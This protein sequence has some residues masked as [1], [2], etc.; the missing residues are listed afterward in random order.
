ML[1]ILGILI[2]LL[3]IVGVTKLFDDKDNSPKQR[4]I[5]ETIYTACFSIGGF[6]VAGTMILYGFRGMFVPP[7]IR[8]IMSLF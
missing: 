8:I 4:K 3:A 5:C 2:L 6:L 7:I 1:K